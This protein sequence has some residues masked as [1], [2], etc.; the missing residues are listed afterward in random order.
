MK[1]RYLD[2]VTGLFV[3]VL[4]ISNVASTKIIALGPFSFDGGTVLFPL[5]Y[6][7]GDILT[8]V[9][10][11]Q[12]SRRVIWT[13]LVS[14]LLMAGFFSLIGWLPADPEWIHQ[15]AY[16]VILLYTPRIIAAS[17]VAY[18][19]GEFTNSYILSKMKI[20]SG[21]RH[22]WQRALGSTVV[23]QLLDTGVFTVI[24]F[25]GTFSNALLLSIFSSNYLFK[26]G[27]EVVNM[28]LT[29][30]VVK[31]L[32]SLE[33]TEVFDYGVDYNPFRLREERED[34]EE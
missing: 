32:K 13:G 34:E 4:L 21:G 5:S 23:G 3:A 6:I 8:E 18:F 1:Y 10:G 24:A 30:I 31:K 7:F 28:P 17:T 20:A 15:E 9:Y 25:Y 14:N 19:L 2:I 22:L 33:Q 11:Y 27:L 26:L 29:Y 12:R 16:Q